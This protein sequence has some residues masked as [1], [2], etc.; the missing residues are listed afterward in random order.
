MKDLERHLKVFGFTL[1]IL[2]GPVK[3]SE[4][5]SDKSKCEFQNGDSGNVLKEGWERGE[6]GGV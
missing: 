6:P 3:D 4:P 1:R 2:G 5:E